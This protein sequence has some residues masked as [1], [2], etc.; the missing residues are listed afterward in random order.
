MVGS[1]FYTRPGRIQMCIGC[2]WCLLLHVLYC[3]V[4]AVAIPVSAT[5]WNEQVVQSPQSTFV[6][7]QCVKKGELRSGAGGLVFR[8]HKRLPQ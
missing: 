8:P 3:I 2:Q 7:Q 5:A 6:M 4:Y 1:P